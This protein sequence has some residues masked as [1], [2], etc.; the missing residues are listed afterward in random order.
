MNAREQYE[1]SSQLIAFC[2]EQIP[3]EQAVLDNSKLLDTRLKVKAQMR[4]V[5]YRLAKNDAEA[6]L[7]D[8]TSVAKG[9]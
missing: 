3:L 7:R 2:D 9:G 6:L 8:A 4:I 5:C 1:L